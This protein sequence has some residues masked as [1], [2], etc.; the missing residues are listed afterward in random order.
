[1]GFC[2]VSGTIPGLVP[3]FY[4]VEEAAVMTTYRLF[5]G[6]VPTVASGTAEGTHG[7]QFSVNVTVTLHAI[8]IYSP[9]GAIELP[10]ACA[11]FEITGV[12]TGTLV[13]ENTSPS[14]S[15]VAGSGWVSCAMGDTETLTPGNNYEACNYN[16][17]G[18]EWFGL[19]ANYWTSGTGASG[20]SNGPLNAPSN[21]SAVNGQDSYV[22]A[23]GGI[24]MPVTSSDGYNYW[25][26]VEVTG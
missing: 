8:W 15:G 24:S 2:P 3:T 17:D 6:T 26:D 7:I 4:P 13:Q 12:G 25:D 20:I 1:M 10:T 21:M 9:P 19:T 5:S 18:N 11:V 14:W 22:L 16:P 23:T